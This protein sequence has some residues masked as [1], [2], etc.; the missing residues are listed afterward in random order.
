MIIFTM[1]SLL[2]YLFHW[3]LSYII[4]MPAVHHPIKS[5]YLHF[6][7][8]LGDFAPALLDVSFGIISRISLGTNH[9]KNYLEKHF[10]AGTLL[11]T[12]ETLL[13]FLFCFTKNLKSF[14]NLKGHNSLSTCAP[15]LSFQ[16]TMSNNLSCCYLYCLFIYLFFFF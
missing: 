10:C 4:A 16:Y 3:Y 13:F 2:I 1:K 11:N 14:C 15:L 7:L 8:I 9:L 6:E 5:S 12:N